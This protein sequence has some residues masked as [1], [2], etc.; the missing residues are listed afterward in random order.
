V[1]LVVDSASGPIYPPIVAKGEESAGPWQWLFER[2]KP[3]GLDLNAVRGV[4]SDGAADLSAYLLRKLVWVAP[5][6]CVWH[7]W[8][9][10]G[11]EL[12]RAA[13]QAAAGLTGEAAQQISKQTRDE[14]AGLIHKIIDAESYAQVGDSA[15]CR[16][17]AELQCRY[18]RACAVPEP[19]AVARNGRILE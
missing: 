17:R 14:L 11:G 9:N 13:S 8:R 15:L 5:Q 4:T 10:L 19:V 16:E 1:L 18:T 3:A 6:R 7:L 2:A 12:W